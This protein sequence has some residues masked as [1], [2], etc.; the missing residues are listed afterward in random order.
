VELNER[1]AGYQ[2]HRKRECQSLAKL[3]SIILVGLTGR[4]I[5]PSILWPEVYPE[6]PVY[7]AEE[8]QK[9]LDEIKKEVGL[10]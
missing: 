1:I 5:R 6:A 4:W 10:N 2:E 9:E 7:T 3:G 8:K